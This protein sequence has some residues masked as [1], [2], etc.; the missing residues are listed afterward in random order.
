MAA[1]EV[2]GAHPLV[3]ED[4]RLRAMVGRLGARLTQ[5]QKV[6]AVQGNAIGALAKAFPQWRRADGRAMI[7]ARAR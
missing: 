2:R 7:A 5:T 3:A 1:R 4:E 6:I